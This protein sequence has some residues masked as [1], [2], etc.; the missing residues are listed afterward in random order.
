MVTCVSQSA[1]STKD[2]KLQTV[3]KKDRVKLAPFDKSIFFCCDEIGLAMVEVV[4]ISGKG[5]VSLLYSVF[6]YEV[7]SRSHPSQLILDIL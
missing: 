7:F 2:K 3:I 6:V 5:S 1:T 4:N